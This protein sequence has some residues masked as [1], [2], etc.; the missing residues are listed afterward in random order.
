MAFTLNPIQAHQA[1]QVRILIS[2]ISPSASN[3][4]NLSLKNAEFSCFYRF[5]CI[6]L[7]YESNP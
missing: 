1:S 7:K 6:N 5:F 2:L 3:A 4:P